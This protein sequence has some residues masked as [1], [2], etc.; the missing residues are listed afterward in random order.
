[1]AAW[2]IREVERDFSKL[3]KIKQV[4]QAD[5]SL[6]EYKLL[7]ENET[8]VGDRKSFHQKENALIYFYKKN[9]IGILSGIVLNL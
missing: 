5:N 6:K 2:G 1:M 9:L 4:L 3:K 7:L 8:K